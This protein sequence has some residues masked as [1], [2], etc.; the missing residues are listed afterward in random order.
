MQT[1]MD[2]N[3]PENV[4]TFLSYLNRMSNTDNALNGQSFNTPLDARNPYVD[5]SQFIF[6]TKNLENTLIQTNVKTRSKL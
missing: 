4:F 1:P 5:G 2:E 3:N 6:K